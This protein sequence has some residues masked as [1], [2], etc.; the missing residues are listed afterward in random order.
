MTVDEAITKIN[1]ALRGI[2]DDA[3]TSGDDEYSYWLSVLNSKKD[4][5]A[6]DIKQRWAELFD[7][8]PLADV[9]ALGV[10]QYDIPTTFLAPSDELYVTH[11]DGQNS[12]FDIIKP[13]QRQR[14]GIRQAYISGINP[15]TLN[16]TTDFVSGDLPIGGT[17]YLPGFYRPADMTDGSDVLPF[18]DPHWGVMAAAAEIAFNDVVYET[19]AADLTEKANDLYRKMAQANRA[20]TYGNGRRAAYNTQNFKYYNPN[21]R[22]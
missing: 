21:S 18:S 2:D 22:R 8:Q 13:Q 11:T 3:P 7:V 4:E 6:Q 19:K 15:K 17:I 14:Y 16:F 1:Y 12:Y 5:Y 9:V 10:Q 20:L